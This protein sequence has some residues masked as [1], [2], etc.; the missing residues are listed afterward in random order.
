MKWELWDAASAFTVDWELCWDHPQ[1]LPGYVQA[2][3]VPKNQD[4]CGGVSAEV[5]PAPNTQVTGSQ[6]PPVSV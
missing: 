1:S 3:L 2:W 5:C 4:H 6:M